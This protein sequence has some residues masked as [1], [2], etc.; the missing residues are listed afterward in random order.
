MLPRSPKT[1][2]WH[3]EPSETPNWLSSEAMPPPLSLPPL[4]LLP[5]KQPQTVPNKSNPSTTIFQAISTSLPMTETL[6]RDTVPCLW[7]FQLDDQ[8]LRKS[9]VSEVQRVLLSRATNTLFPF[10]SCPMFSM[11]CDNTYDTWCTNTRHRF[12]FFKRWKA[13][14]L[15]LL[16]AEG[17]EYSSL[18]DICEARSEVM[19]AMEKCKVTSAMPVWWP[20][21]VSRSAMFGLAASVFTFSFFI[22]SSSARDV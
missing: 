21:S 4:L 18:L 7:N 17:D 3:A 6:L 1:L 12:S 8:D 11:T 2:C 19:S 10:C 15:I 13:K 9:C 14:L 22:T 5:T 20:F 16:Q